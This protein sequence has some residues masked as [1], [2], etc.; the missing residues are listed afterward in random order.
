MREQ[1]DGLLELIGEV[2]TITPDRRNT[3]RKATA[4]RPCTNLRRKGL[5]ARK[6][7]KAGLMSCILVKGRAGA[8]TPANIL[9]ND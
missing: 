9:P 6:A 5:S 2:D 1:L 7:L 3:N 4:K 8:N